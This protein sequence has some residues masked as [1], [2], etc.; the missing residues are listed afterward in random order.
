MQIQEKRRTLKLLEDE[1]TE[2]ANIV[3]KLDGNIDGNINNILMREIDKINYKTDL[4]IQNN[5]SKEG[6][7][8]PMLVLITISTCIILYFVY[9]WTYYI[10]PE[11]IQDL[12][13]QTVYNLINGLTN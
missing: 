7:T 9:R 12:F 4:L 13:N 8:L 6:N 11:N 5:N 2:K 3:N 10:Q 1:I